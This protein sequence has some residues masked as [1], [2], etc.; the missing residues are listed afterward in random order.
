LSIAGVSCHAARIFC[1][2]KR[3]GS[4]PDGT[5]WYYNALAEVFLKAMPG[6]LT[7]RTAIEAR[8]KLIAQDT[9]VKKNGFRPNWQERAEQSLFGP[10]KVAAK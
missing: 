5:R 8:P 1:D 3:Q 10:Y 7:D 4:R 2:N 9:I 6:R